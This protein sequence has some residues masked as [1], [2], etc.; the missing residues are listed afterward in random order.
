MKQGGLFDGR[1]LLFGS[2]SPLKNINS[3]YD[4]VILH[5]EKKIIYTRRM[6]I[7]GIQEILTAKRNKRNEL[8]T[9]YNRGF[10]IIGVIDNCLGVTAVGLVELAFS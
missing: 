10:N 8:S 7:D 2:N 1:G 4:F 9:K 6:E 3:W 5:S